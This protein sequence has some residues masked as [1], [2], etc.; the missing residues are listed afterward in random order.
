L[1]EGFAQKSFKSGLAVTAFK[2][3]LWKSGRPANRRNKQVKFQKTIMH[4]SLSSKEFDKF[5]SFWWDILAKKNEK[6]ADHTS[7]PRPI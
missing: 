6:L 7:Q 3:A 2:R 4:A 1:V 5:K